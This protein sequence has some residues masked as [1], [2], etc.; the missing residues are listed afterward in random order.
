M[1]LR[2]IGHIP[3]RFHIPSGDEIEQA[4]ALDVRE[5]ALYVPALGIVHE[6]RAD[7]RRI[8]QHITRTFR[9]QH[10]VTVQRERISSNSLPLT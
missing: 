7:E 8:A 9:R 6:F 1:G 4:A 2:N 5:H 10:V 3:R